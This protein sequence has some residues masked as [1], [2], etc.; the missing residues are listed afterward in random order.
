MSKSQSKGQNMKGRNPSDTT[1]VD[2][3]N[4]TLDANLSAQ[5]MNAGADDTSV[6][7]GKA[8][9]AV[10]AVDEEG[11]S[12]S[13]GE[14]ETLESSSNS[15]PSGS[16]SSK[17]SEESGNLLSKASSAFE[18]LDAQSVKKNLNLVKHKA[19]GLLSSGREQISSKYATLSDD[20]KLRGMIV[21]DK[22]KASP[23]AYALGAAGIGF[24][25]G[26]ALSGKGK[27]DL[28][29]LMST[30]NKMNLSSLASMV[31]MKVEDVAAKTSDEA[32]TTAKVG[33]NEKQARKIG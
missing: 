11:S 26:R 15:V 17:V 21:D 4:D 13:F 19:Q 14:P 33:Y 6:N 5:S 7:T 1:N 10:S 16:I 28:D 20:V 30:V 25:L 9:D 27:Q 18:G 22:V 24:I 32:S 31:G 29:F 3:G 12:H 8:G 2:D 23:Y